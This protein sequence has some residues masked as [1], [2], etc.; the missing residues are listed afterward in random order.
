MPTSTPTENNG[1]TDVAAPTTPTRDHPTNPSLPPKKPAGKASVCQMPGC[2]SPAE[3]AAIHCSLHQPEL[4][5][6][7]NALVAACGKESRWIGWKIGPRSDGDPT[8]NK[9]PISP[10]TGGFA[11]SDNPATWATY[12]DAAAFVAANGCDSIGFVLTDLPGFTRMAIVDFDHVCKAGAEPPASVLRIAELL[13]D[14]YTERSA[15]GEGFHII[16]FGTVAK[17]VNGKKLPGP[18]AKEQA[19]EVYGSKKMFAVSLRPLTVANLVNY[20]EGAKLFQKDNAGEGGR[21]LVTMFTSMYGENKHTAGSLHNGTWVVVG[22]NVSLLLA[23]TGE[24]FYKALTGSGNIKDGFLSRCTIVADYRNPV[25]GDWPA[26]DQERVKEL[27]GRLIECQS[28][29]ELPEDTDATAARHVFLKHAAGLD[30]N[31]SAR[32]VSL[33]TQDLYARSLFSPEG[34][35]TVQAVERARK[36]AEHQYLTR[37]VLWPPDVSKDKVETMTALL[38]RAYEKHT[39]LSHTQAKRIANVGRPGSGGEHVYFMAHRAL[40]NTGT[41]FIAGKN[42]KGK[43]LFEYADGGDK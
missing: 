21:G 20:D 30:P 13:E 14:S 32:V 28:R 40:V 29:K 33:F 24:S 22:A 10:R 41:I 15:S 27:V 1:A 9:K 38:R 42:R 11:S 19:V 6:P 18:C 8:G 16:V 2:N 26:V 31:Y 37:Q 5:A 35:V 12:D 39:R 34:R 7:T 23:F 36:W 43:D 4:F 25:E 17:N 3:P